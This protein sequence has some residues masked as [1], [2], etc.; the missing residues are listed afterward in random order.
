MLI[1]YQKSFAGFKA[2]ETRPAPDGVAKVLIRKG[3]ATIPT[4]EVEKKL[5][6]STVPPP[7]APKRKK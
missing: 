6:K 5:A 3:Y 1:T 4:V 7:T 2:G